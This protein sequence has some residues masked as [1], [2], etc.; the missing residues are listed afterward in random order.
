[1]GSVR[2]LQFKTE[3]SR[4]RER[5]ADIFEKLQSVWIGSLRLPEQERRSSFHRAALAA[6][7]RERLYLTA[8]Q[9]VRELTVHKLF[10]EAVEQCI[11]VV[12]CHNVREHTRA[13]HFIEPAV[14]ERGECLIRHEGA[15]HGCGDPVSSP[16]WPAEVRRTTIV[17]GFPRR[18]FVPVLVSYASPCDRASCC[19]RREAQDWN[20]RRGEVDRV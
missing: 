5:E 15:I 9:R 3:A 18:S 4:P 13:C 6:K 7:G 11:T 12:A 2:L 19:R 14:H 8:S 1:M 16:P 17:N 10:R 20:N